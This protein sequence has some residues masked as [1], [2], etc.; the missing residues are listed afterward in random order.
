MARLYLVRH[1]RARAGWEE[2]DPGLDDLGRVQAAAMAARLAPLG[3]LALVSSPLARA[4]ETAVPLEVRWGVDADIAE[5]VREVPSPA[6]VAVADRP[7]WLR[8]AMAGTWADLDDRFSRYRDGVVAC[9]RGLDTDT[10]VTSHFIAINAVI[11]AAV[12]DDRIVIRSLDNC[13]VTVID[14]APDGLVL[15]EAGH[16]A[17]TLIR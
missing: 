12:G 5:A 9:L 17:D 7:M 13:S 10:V 2:Q 3:P 11:G 16:E 14:Q 6:G 4:R 8:E 1:G 15:V